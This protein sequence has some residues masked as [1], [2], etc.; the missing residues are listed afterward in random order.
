LIDESQ[1]NYGLAATKYRSAIETDPVY[2]PALFNLAIL[3]T[4]PDPAE[5]I[6]L[7]QRA[8][9]ANPRTPRPC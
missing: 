8:V 1:T 9:K 6:S 4:A 5:A 3:R 2:V 7:Y